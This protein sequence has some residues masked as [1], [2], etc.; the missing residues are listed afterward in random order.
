MNILR[1][2]IFVLALIVEEDVALAEATK[3]ILNPPA[4]MIIS[5]IQGDQGLSLIV[6]VEDEEYFFDVPVLREDIENT[7]TFHEIV[8]DITSDLNNVEIDPMDLTITGGTQ[9]V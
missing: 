8:F 3:I 9:N 5:V 6:S 7:I 2:I 1:I 4:T